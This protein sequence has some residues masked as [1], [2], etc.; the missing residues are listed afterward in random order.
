MGWLST[1]FR[2]KN[3]HPNRAT[4]S[5]SAEATTPPPYVSLILSESWHL[6]HASLIEGL[7][8]QLGYPVDHRDDLLVITCDA[9]RAKQ[10]ELARKLTALGV[11][12]S[13][14]P[15]SPSDVLGFLQDDGLLTEP[16]TEIYW[17]APGRWHTRSV[18]K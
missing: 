7:I 9:D 13:F 12:F 3:K 8:T 14:G 1:L 6:K 17:T 18:A 5:S 4:V 15:N 2:K 16:F 11:A 10:A